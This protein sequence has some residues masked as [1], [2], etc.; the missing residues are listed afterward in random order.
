MGGMTNPPSDSAGGKSGSGGM[1][2][3]SGFLDNQTDKGSRAQ[4][5]YGP[6]SDH[7]NTEVGG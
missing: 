2:D 1:P 7:T 3:Q 4:Q 5:G 6:G